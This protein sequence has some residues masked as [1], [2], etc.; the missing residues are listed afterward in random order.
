[1]GAAAAVGWLAHNAGPHLT[2]HETDH[3][4][5]NNRIPGSYEDQ[6][7]SEISELSMPVLDYATACFPPPLCLHH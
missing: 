5:N 4:I 7:C 3:C 6:R 2:E 1:V